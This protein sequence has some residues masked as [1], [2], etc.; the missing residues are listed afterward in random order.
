[1]RGGVPGPRTVPATVCSVPLIG[2]AGEVEQ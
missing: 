1:M 2:T